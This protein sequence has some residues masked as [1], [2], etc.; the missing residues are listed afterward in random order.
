MGTR[1]MCA[2]EC[3][4]HE[5]VKGKVVGGKDRDTVVT[6]YSTGHPV[7]V[8]KNKLTRQ[9]E[10]LDRANKP[11]EVEMLGAGKLQ[12]AMRKGDLEMGSLMAGQAA[13]LV[14]GVQPADEII[15]EI[16]AEAIAVM[17][18][19]GRGRG[20]LGR[21]CRSPSSFQARGPSASAC[22][23]RC[24]ATTAW[25]GC[26]TPPRRSPALPL[27]ARRRRGPGRQARRHAR[28]AAAAVPGRLGLGRGARWRP[29]RSPAAVAGHSLGEFAAL[30]IAG[31]FSVEAGL[32]LVIERS[33][34]MAAAATSTPGG[35]AAVLG[36]EARRR[37][38]VRRRR[39][40]ASG[41]PTTTLP[42]RSSSRGRTRGIEKATEALTGRGARR[43]VPPEGGGRV[44]QPAHGGGGGQPSPR[45]C[46]PRRRSRTR[47]SR[48]SA[49]P[50][51]RRRSTPT[52]C[53]AASP[54]RWSRRSDGP[55]RCTRSP[56]SDVTTLV[57]AG[58]GSVLT[59]LAR[60]VDGLTATA[61]EESGVDAAMEEV[62]RDETRR[63]R[64]RWSP[65][66]RAASAPRSHARWPPRARTV[67]VN[68]YPSAGDADAAAGVVAELQSRRRDRLGLPGGRLR[69]RR[70]APRWSSTSSPRRGASTSS[71]TTPGI[72]RDGLL[73]RMSD[74]DWH[75]VID[76]DLTSVFACTRAAARPMM[77]QRAGS[78]VN[79][80]SVVG[81]HGQRRDRPTTRRPR[82]ASSG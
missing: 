29:A 38:R 69:R 37:S 53:D 6:G 34:L 32:E 51:P 28:G 44:P 39:S 43:V 57:E 41:S 56:S 13:A 77:K 68:H 19:I 62:A 4:I 63:A 26:S 3:T 21:P 30:T 22:S 66:R 59:G 55:R 70:R 10:E 33:R 67:L 82:R 27:V 48:S 5:S 35:M 49:T 9:I 46:S 40:T 58:P 60:R 61:V 71:S 75:A 16:V 24:G 2:T 23:T 72:T 14:T 7:R 79:I 65:A 64:S 17:R 45:T 18:G 25:S 81:R 74:D 31:V 11:D 36:L 52:S 15:D 20:P 54:C 76:T 12:L 1:F 42:A 47:A 8:I 50:S 78:I 73:V 80:A